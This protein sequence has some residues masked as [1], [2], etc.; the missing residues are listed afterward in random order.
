MQMGQPPSEKFERLKPDYCKQN[1][2]KTNVNKN[3]KNAFKDDMFFFVCVFNCVF[4]F[5]SLFVLF[6]EILKASFVVYIVQ[7]KQQ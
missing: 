2:T 1:E 3:L 7:P 5:F 4:C 6:F